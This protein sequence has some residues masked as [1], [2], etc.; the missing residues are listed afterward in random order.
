MIEIPVAW[1]EMDAARHLNNAVYIRYMESGR[2]ALF[3]EWDFT[4]FSGGIGPIL[5]E[6][7]CRYKAP[8]TFPDTVRV[9]TGVVNGSLHAYGFELQHLMI[10][11][12]LGRIVAEGHSVIV[13]YDYTGLSKTPL[14]EPVVRKIREA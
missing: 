8:V 3:R 2:I 12:Q 9:A 4:G 11:S 6:V 7:R 5:A 13:S 10:S 1:G 14:P